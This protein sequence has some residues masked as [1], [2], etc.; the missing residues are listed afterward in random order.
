MLW[1]SH[2]EIIEENKA[3]AQF[4]ALGSQSG[5]SYSHAGKKF[6]LKV[7]ANEIAIPLLLVINIVR[8]APIKHWDIYDRLTIGLA[9]RFEIPEGAAEEPKQLRDLED[10][11]RHRG[12]SL[13][14]LSRAT[15]AKWK[16]AVR[17][18]FR[19]V[20]GE[21]FDEHPRLQKLKDAVIRH[22]KDE[23]GKQG[24]GV[25]RQAILNKVLQ[26]LHSIAPLD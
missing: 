20:F 5:I 22:A 21:K 26:A 23:Y 12:K 3:F 19:I 9:G 16:P 4:L 13:P 11:R 25:V 2:P 18:V 14:P 10:W 17:D 6:S 24:P 1:E 15:L 8:R 7:P